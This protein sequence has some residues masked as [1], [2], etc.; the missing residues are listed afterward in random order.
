MPQHLRFLRSQLFR[1]ERSALHHSSLNTT[2]EKDSSQ[3]SQ[4][5][6]EFPRILCTPHLSLHLV[7]PN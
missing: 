7:G 3:L 6:K 4:Q 2:G 1:Q 5:R